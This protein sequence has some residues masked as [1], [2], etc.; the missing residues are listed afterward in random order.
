M[1][2]DFVIVNNCKVSSIF[3]KKK[4]KGCTVASQQIK[5]FVAITPTNQT[6]HACKVK[7]VTMA[8]GIIQLDI[9]S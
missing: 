8:L 4:K 2:F 6:P 9:F 1:D 7:L 5:E 3:Q